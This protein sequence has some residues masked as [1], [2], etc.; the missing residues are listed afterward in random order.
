MDVVYFDQSVQDFIASLES[1]TYAKTLRT[2]H[3][4]VGYGYL[5]MM[6]HSKH[7]ESG[8][9]ELRV[10]GKQEVRLLYTFHNEQAI[11]LHGFVKK[12]EKTLAPDLQ[13]ARNRRKTLTHI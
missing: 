6:P 11:I 13:L 12:S 1:S 8:L 5:L 3:L 10:R 7:V 9:W 4:L 2:I